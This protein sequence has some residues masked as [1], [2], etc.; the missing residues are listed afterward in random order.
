MQK[1]VPCLW[2]DGRIEEAVGFYMSLFPGARVLK[3]T[4]YGEAG[5]LPEGTVMTVSIEIAG[6]EVM[7]LNG[8]Q[9]IDFSPAVSFVVKCASQVEIDRLWEAL[10]EGGETQHCGW[11]T[12]RFGLSWQVI[13]E[14]LPRLMTGGE[15][16][17]NRVMAAILGM[18][19]LDVA[20]LERAHASA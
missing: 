11:V 5:P 6:Q 10:G 9:R 7:A 20:A 17:V 2:L 4:H 12:D 16:A 18:R 19:K 13:P 8:G 14:A 15:A 1:I 3:V